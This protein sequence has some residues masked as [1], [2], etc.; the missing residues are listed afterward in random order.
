M[1]KHQKY[2]TKY[3][4]LM[5]M[6]PEV[7][8]P[9]PA[10]D[11]QSTLLHEPPPPGFKY[12]NLHP[13][14][15]PSQTTQQKKDPIGH[16]KHHVT[17]STFN[18]PP[19]PTFEDF[20]NPIS[21]LFDG[22]ETFQRFLNKVELALKEYKTAAKQNLRNKV[23]TDAPGARQQGTFKGTTEQTELIEGHIMNY[24]SQMKQIWEY[25]KVLYI[26][27]QNTFANKDT[28]TLIKSYCGSKTIANEWGNIDLGE[29]PEFARDSCT[30][31]V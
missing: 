5:G 13:V 26:F 2:K 25:I 16:E 22:H 24:K 20:P 27:S 30:T 11:P 7:P 4:S 3:H 23:D 12:V 29:D 18:L 28:K 21:D 9:E 14:F 1:Y 10:I 6:G 31:S 19:E 17:Y 15:D 8:L